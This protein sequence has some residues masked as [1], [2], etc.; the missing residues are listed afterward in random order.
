VNTPTVLAIVGPTASGKTTLSLD[1][2]QLLG[3]EIVSA[4]SRQ[5]Y[6]H[7][8]IGTAKPSRS[9]RNRIPHYLID[10]LEPTEE[11]SAGQFGKEARR[12]FNEIKARGR[13]PFLVGGSGLY[14]RAA[15]DGLVDVPEADAEI[16]KQLA[17]QHKREGLEGLVKELARVDRKSLERMK[18]VNA[19][20]V[21]RALEVYRITGI[22]L[23]ELHQRQGT[24]RSVDALQIGLQWRRS[25]LYR[26]IDERVDRMMAEGLVD[27]TRHLLEMGFNRNL[28]AFNSVGYK[29]VCDFLDGKLNHNT[30]VELIKRNTRR[31]AKRQT[32][33]FKADKRIRWIEMSEDAELRD[34][35]EAIFSLY[36][37]SVTP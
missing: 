23:S 25:E 19:R 3:G 34:T 11:Y 4:D 7:I 22:P 15:L 37:E 36:R 17:D 20:R 30:M 26:R 29:E 27:E 6:K 12:I 8:D 24:V 9:E 33:W 16:R 21:I 1:V 2:A 18:E 5:I 35:R 28:N 32:T 31:F 13:I 14:I 10:L